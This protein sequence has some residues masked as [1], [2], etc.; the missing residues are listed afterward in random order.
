MNVNQESREEKAANVIELGACRK[1]FPPSKPSREHAKVM[2]EIACETSIGDEI[3]NC[4]IKKLEQTGCVTISHYRPDWV[5]SIICLEY[6]NLVEMSLVLREL[7]RSTTPGTE[8][9]KASGADQGMLRY[10]GWVYESLRYHGLHGVPKI[11]LG[12]FLKSL[13]EEFTIRHLGLVSAR[14]KMRT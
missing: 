5:F 9:I 4:L 14:L 6:G 2:I 7:F 3:R 10:G 11:G 1:N 8:V 12:D 13:A